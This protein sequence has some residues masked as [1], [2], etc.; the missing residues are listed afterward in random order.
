MSPSN[1]NSLIESSK[2]G[3]NF[4]NQQLHKICDYG[5]LPAYVTME[6]LI[7]LECISIDTIRMPMEMFDPHI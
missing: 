5:A 1:A 4:L 6:T 3:G 2:K 7:S